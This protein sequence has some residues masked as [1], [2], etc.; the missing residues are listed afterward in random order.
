MFWSRRWHQIFGGKLCWHLYGGCV[1]DEREHIGRPSRAVGMER[2]RLTWK[3]FEKEV[4]ELNSPINFHH[5]DPMVI[6]KLNY[7]YSITSN[8]SIFHR[9]DGFKFLLITFGSPKSSNFR[10]PVN[11]H[12]I[13]TTL[14]IIAS[15]IHW[16][17]V[18]PH[19]QICMLKPNPQND[20]IEKWDL[21][22]VNRSW[23]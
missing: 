14:R 4:I 18:C 23:G 5:K 13:S 12:Y 19:P 22:E 21:W 20:G 3:K 2:R 10:L 7:A 15:A 17:F 8:F 1:G 11:I 6:L 9:R 16:V